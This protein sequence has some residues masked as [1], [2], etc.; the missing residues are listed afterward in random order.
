MT[1]Y[2][3]INEEENVI[4]KLGIY[5]KQIW[6]LVIYFENNELKYTYFKSTISELV[7]LKNFVKNL[8]EKK[9]PFLVFAIWHDSYRTDA[10]LFRPEYIDKVPL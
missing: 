4:E 10:F 3:R 6:W 7:S 8:N 9:I 5:K 2:V 1:R